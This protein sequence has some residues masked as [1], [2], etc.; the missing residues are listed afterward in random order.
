MFH[1]LISHYHPPMAI[2]IMAMT[3]RYIK[4]IMLWVRRWK[5]NGPNNLINCF[6][7][8][9]TT[10]ALIISRASCGRHRSCHVATC[11]LTT[12]TRYRCANTCESKNVCAIIHHQWHVSRRAMMD[13]RCMWCHDMACWL[14]SCHV[15]CNWH[16]PTCH[17][18][19]SDMSHMCRVV[20]FH[21]MLGYQSDYCWWIHAMEGKH[22]MVPIGWKIQ[23][24]LYLSCS[25]GKPGS[26]RFG[27][28]IS[29]Y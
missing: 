18:S 14:M 29:N 15:V 27:V 28:C 24:S 8:E 10:D 9:H 26:G 21:V 22:Y 3:T 20:M 13:A 12:R 11:T 2:R 23:G 4:M 19:R 16:Q 7:F 1:V 5:R 25:I 6:W 17:T